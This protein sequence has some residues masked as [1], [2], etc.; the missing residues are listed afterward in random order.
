MSKKTFS[1][2]LENELLCKLRIIAAY[3]KRSLS[4]QIRF[5]IRNCIRRY[6]KTYGEI[7]IE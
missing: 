1:F 7:K 5:L 3:E 6:E 4:S 2:R